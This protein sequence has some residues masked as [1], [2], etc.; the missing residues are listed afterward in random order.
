[1]LVEMRLMDVVAPKARA[2]ILLRS[3][4]RAG[5]VHLTPFAL[6]PGAGQLVFR[7]G[8][9]PAAAGPLEIALERVSELQRLIG[10][11]EVPPE[12]VAEL[13]Q[14][15]D[16]AFLRQLDVLEPTHARASSIAAERVRLLGQQARTQEYRN[17][18]EGL[19]GIADRLPA[20]RGYATTAIVIQPRY[21][22]VLALLRDELEALTAGICELI[23]AGLAG[24]QVED[25]L[26]RRADGAGGEVVGRAI[27]E[28]VAHVTPAAARSSPTTLTASTTGPAPPPP[29][30]PRS[31]SQSASAMTSRLCS[32]RTTV[33]PVL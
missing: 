16:G 32:I 6:P 21:R 31:T 23:A 7:T 22:H 14:L 28:R 2:A 13:W 11:A 5:T 24:L 17:L 4:H 30:G 1:M 26:A 10:E 8:L 3:L 18:V 15:D 19:Q 33:T 20:I 9:E 29:A 25:A 12:L 27:L